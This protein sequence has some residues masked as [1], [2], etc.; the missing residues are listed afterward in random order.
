MDLGLAGRVVI[1]TGA[2]A[3]IGRGIALAFAA[4][5]AVVIGV[6]RDA[7]AGGRLVDAALAAG[8]AGAAGAQ[9]VAADLRDPAAPARIVAL[10]EAHGAVAALANGVGG[11]VDQGLF[12]ESDPAKWAADIDLNFGTVLRM[13][14]ACCPA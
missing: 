1:V 3:N 7:L 14:H 13:T 4:E 5:G 6:G 2:T 10:A 8:A 12:A 9:F 11:N